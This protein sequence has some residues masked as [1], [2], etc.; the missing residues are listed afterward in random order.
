M[1]TAV[2][3]TVTELPESR[4]RVEAEIPADEVQRTLETTARKL[5]GNMNLPGFRKGKIPTPVLIQRI[6]R[7][8]LMDEAVREG[9]G[10]WYM[11]VVEE[12]GIAPIGDPDLHM[13]DLPDEGQALTFSLEVGVRPV[14]TLGEYKGLEVARREPAA[15]PAAIDAEI[16]TARERLSR[17]EVVD[18]PAEEGDFVIVDFLGRLDDVPFEGGEGRDQVVEIGSGRFIAGFEEAL[19]GAEAGEQRTVLT[20][21]PAEYPKEDLAGREA[22]FTV[23]VKEV[24][25]K[26]LPDLDDELAVQ[27]GFDTLDEARAD[28]AER[29]READAEAVQEEFREAAID[30]AVAQAEIDVP[31]D[32]V[33]WR[34]QELWDRMLD[35][36]ARQRISKELYLQ[37]AGKTEAEA[38]KEA[39]PEAEQALRREAVIVAIVEAEGIAPTDDELLE[40]IRP[41]AESEGITR[42]QLR[43]QMREAGRLGGLTEQLAARQA[44]DL[45]TESAVPVSP[46]KAEASGKLWAPG[47]DK[48]AGGKLW[49]PDS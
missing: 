48:P 17:L 33:K 32:L 7:R 23:D 42:F 20:T 41:A 35:S 26:Q 25:V 8:T 22:E 9:M 49:T 40:A 21:F 14:A 39:L 1:T 6:G 27:L 36:L 19:A 5:G 18:R 37:I 29:L 30:A 34:A 38:L 47:Q 11:R 4:V 43:D 10:Q 44:I 24:K 45:V 28:I 15:D 2:K 16:E 31:Q 3:T 46:E 12:A 13:G